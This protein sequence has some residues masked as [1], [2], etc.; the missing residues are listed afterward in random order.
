MDPMTLAAGLVA[1]VARL[2][3]FLT[4][5]GESAGNAAATSVGKAIGDAAVKRSTALWDRLWP[6]LRGQDS[7][8]RAVAAVAT[9]PDGTSARRQLAHEIAP[10][11]AGDP[12]LAH[13]VA[14]LIRHVKD[15]G[16]AIDVGDIS[17]KGD[18]NVVQVGETNISIGAASD[19]HIGGRP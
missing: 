13:E 9:D 4:G 18:G 19:V 6:N 8:R 3:P 17:V 7:A 2:L 5:I 11:L 12:E 15:R 10:L 16:V 1:V 14:A